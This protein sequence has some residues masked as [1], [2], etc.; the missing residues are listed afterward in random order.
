MSIKTNKESFFKETDNIYLVGLKLILLL[1]LLLKGR[2]FL[3]KI[4]AKIGC[5]YCAD[6]VISAILFCQN[7]FSPQCNW[8]DI[9]KK[10]DEKTTVALLL[11]TCRCRCCPSTKL[12]F[13]PL[14]LTYC[15]FNKSEILSSDMTL[16]LLLV[17]M[18]LE[19]SDQ[20]TYLIVFYF[21]DFKEKSMYM[22]NRAIILTNSPVVE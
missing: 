6:D 14:K 9:V 18:A 13:A 10:Y 5:K 17:I 19:L 2:L 20:N 11:Q 1:F 22:Y 21:S 16:Q 3:G 8:K 4:E 12:H 7:A 15:I